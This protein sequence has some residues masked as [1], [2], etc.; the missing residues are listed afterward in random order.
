MVGV[1]AA[2]AAH[3]A[4]LVGRDALAS[5]ECL[6]CAR[7]DADLDL[8][9]NEG[10]RNRVEEVMDLDVIIEL[11]CARRHSALSLSSAGKPLS[12]ARSTFSNSSRRL[13]PRWRMVRSFMRCMT[14]VMA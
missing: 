4:A 7:R 1:R 3:V 10:V 11:T 6:D 9:A 2:F 8:G 5:M 13:R 14:S 12:A